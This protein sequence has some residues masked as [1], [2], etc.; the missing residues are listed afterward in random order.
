MFVGAWPC[1]R[2]QRQHPNAPHLTPSSCTP[3]SHYCQPFHQS[4]DSHVAEISQAPSAT[5]LSGGRVLGH[6]SDVTAQL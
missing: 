5:S 2:W 3:S 4:S 1:D 6:W